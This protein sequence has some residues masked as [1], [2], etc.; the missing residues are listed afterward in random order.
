MTLS[1]PAPRSLPKP[2]VQISTG[3]FWAFRLERAFDLIA[4]AGFTEVELMVTRDPETH[5]PDTPLEL[6][7]ERGLA[8][9]SVHGPFLVV[10]KS[11]WGLA[12]LEKI[13]KGIDMCRAVGASTLIVHPPHPWETTYAEWIVDETAA[14]ELATGVTVAVETMYPLWVAGRRVCG[15]QWLE[16]WE[17]AR[18]APRTAMDTSHLAVAR[19]DILG[20]CD[21]LSNGLAHVHLSNN[22]GDG[23]DGHLE[24]DKGV[25]PVGDLLD[26][27]NRKRYT[28]ALSLEL[29]V[30]RYLERPRDLVTMLVHNRQLVEE[31]MARPPVTEAQSPSQ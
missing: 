29:S 23:R 25:L 18:H 7:S 22:A 26:E 15:Y 14:C 12:P 28:G 1:D 4:D 11:V 5:E 10:T 30:S 27:L 24:L 16:P 13:K 9:T 17:L 6:A 2:P 31:R 20:A 19:E 21:V 3:P 8:I